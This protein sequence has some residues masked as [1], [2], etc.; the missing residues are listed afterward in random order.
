MVLGLNAAV[1][2]TNTTRELSALPSR[3]GQNIARPSISPRLPQLLASSLESATSQRRLIK[4][5]ALNE[6]S[7]HTPDEMPEEA[8]QSTDIDDNPIPLSEPFIDEKGIEILDCN[9][10]GKFITEDGYPLDIYIDKAVADKDFSDLNSI[11]ELKYVLNHDDRNGHRTMHISDHF[12]TNE[13]F[14]AKVMRDTIYGQWTEENGKPVLDLSMHVNDNAE[15]KGPLWESAAKESDLIPPPL[16]KELSKIGGEMRKKIFKDH[17]Q[18]SLQAMALG[19]K[20]LLDQHPELK[21]AKTQLRYLSE[22]PEINETK[23]TGLLE[24]HLDKPILAKKAPLAQVA[25]NVQIWGDAMSSSTKA[26]RQLLDAVLKPESLGP[27]LKNP[28]TLAPT[29]VL[30]IALGLVAANSRSNSNQ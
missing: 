5:Q 30:L 28:K 11:Y 9:H 18:D 1:T 3:L 6:G 21:L 26:M 15:G 25:A 7:P 16:A 8:L 14:Y 12:P 27:L 17:V 24:T 20:H 22:I 4:M 13:S 19:T 2:R 29:L 23:D 10:I